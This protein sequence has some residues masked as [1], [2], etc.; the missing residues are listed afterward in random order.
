M[1]RTSTRLKDIRNIA[2]LPADLPPGVL[3]DWVIEE[4]RREELRRREDRPGLH[5]PLPYE[6]EPPR[7]A[8]KDEPAP[9]SVTTFD[10]ST[11]L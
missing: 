4:K 6:T 11:G 3:P 8:P 7:P 10:I 9:P 2:D 1:G 5:L